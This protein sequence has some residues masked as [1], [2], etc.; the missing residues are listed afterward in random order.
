MRDVADAPVPRP[1]ATITVQQT[2]R[3]S[4]KPPGYSRIL[5]S[6][7][8][9]VPIENIRKLNVR[10]SLRLFCVFAVLDPR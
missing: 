10:L 8:F 2:V 7:R 4:I 3:F 1:Q 9:L 6:P 5:A